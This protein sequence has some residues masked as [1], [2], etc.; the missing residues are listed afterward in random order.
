LQ[1]RHCW[2]LL[3]ERF[4]HKRQKPVGDHDHFFEPKQRETHSNAVLPTE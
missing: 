2:R 3:M 1:Q 4:T